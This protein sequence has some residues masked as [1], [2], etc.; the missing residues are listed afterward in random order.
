M[1]A[2]VTGMG[3]HRK[4]STVDDQSEPIK[5]CFTQL[6]NWWVAYSCLI[7]YF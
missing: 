3:F 2:I 7:I 1:F 6:Y 5:Y 4:G